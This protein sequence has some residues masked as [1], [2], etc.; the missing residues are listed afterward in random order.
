MASFLWI[1]VCIYILQICFLSTTPYWSTNTAASRVWE[2]SDI[3]YFRNAA[4][5][6]M[7]MILYFKDRNIETAAV[8]FSQALSNSANRFID[9]T[10]SVSAPLSKLFKEYGSLPPCK[11]QSRPGSMAEIWNCKLFSNF[12][13]T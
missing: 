3:P 13:N 12:F 7:M 6:I 1:K 8:Y 2:N 11:L 5:Y 10:R 4:I 9:S